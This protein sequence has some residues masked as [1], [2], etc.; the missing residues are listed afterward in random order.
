MEADAVVPVNFRLLKSI[1]TVLTHVRPLLL[2]I[3]ERKYI[4]IA[5]NSMGVPAFEG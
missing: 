5:R 1:K 2:T 4:F 3:N